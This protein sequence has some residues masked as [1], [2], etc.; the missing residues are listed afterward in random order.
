MY[1]QIY[2]ICW[3]YSNDATKFIG[4]K[5]MHDINTGH[6]IL[7]VQSLENSILYYTGLS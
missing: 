5:Y 4:K 7:H 6:N 2:N 3:A 1:M